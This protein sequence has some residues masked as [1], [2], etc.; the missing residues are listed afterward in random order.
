MGKQGCGARHSRGVDVLPSEA[1]RDALPNL[2]GLISTCCGFVC[3]N[4]QKF[5]FASKQPG[6][7]LEGYISA[8]ARTW[9][10]QI[11]QI[12]LFYF[13]NHPNLSTTLE[14]FCTLPSYDVK[15]IFDDFSKVFGCPE[16]NA[17]GSWPGAE[18]Q[19]KPTARP[20]R[21]GKLA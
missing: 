19:V 18:T 5:V 12:R 13:E 10:E 21:E 4:A 3:K 14:V 2:E 17:N 6:K 16:A 20:Q 1:F 15:R 8:A 9:T 7:K 11:S